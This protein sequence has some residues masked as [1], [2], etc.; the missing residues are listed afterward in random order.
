M[1]L[2]SKKP[3][4]TFFGNLLRAGGQAVSKAAG[5]PGLLGSGANRI[6]LGQ[7]QTNAQL[8]AAT[9][10]PLTPAISAPN[11]VTVPNLGGI[12]GSTSTTSAS[13]SGGNNNLLLIIGAAVAALFLLNKKR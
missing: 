12:F 10:A 2:F 4:G 5:V 3:G 8:S 11:T 7:T 6:E 13:G 9:S 1:G